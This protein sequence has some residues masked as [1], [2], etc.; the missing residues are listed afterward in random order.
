[1]KNDWKEKHTFF[2]NIVGSAGSNVKSRDHE[3]VDDT[4]F[5]S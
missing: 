3:N 4:V 5:R 2:L 1:M